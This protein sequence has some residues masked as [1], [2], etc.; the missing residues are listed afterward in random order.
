MD[1]RLRFTSR[2]IKEI[3]HALYYERECNH[4]T[5]GHNV[6]LLLARF[7]QF[8]GFFLDEYNNLSVPETVVIE[9]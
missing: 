5:V 4:G 6:L 3:Q 9:G 1:N 8:H 7:A 2:E